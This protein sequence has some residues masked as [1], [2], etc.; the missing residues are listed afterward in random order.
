MSDQAQVLFMQRTDSLSASAKLFDVPEGYG[1]HQ[2][3]MYSAPTFWDDWQ[4]TPDRHPSPAGRWFQVPDL[5][6]PFEA[7]DTSGKPALEIVGIFSRNVDSASE[8]SGLG[9]RAHRETFAALL[10][11]WS[12]AAQ[13]ARSQDVEG[14]VAGYVVPSLVAERLYN[15][16]RLTEMDEYGYSCSQSA[17]DRL[18]ALAARATSEYLAGDHYSLILPIITVSEDGGIDLQWRASNR[19]VLISIPGERSEE[20]RY[21]AHDHLLPDR[22]IG[23]VLPDETSA[24]F[25]LVWLNA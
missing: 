7:L 9:S 12:Q 2:G 3:A 6:E 13:P 1:A 18:L 20:I 8:L 11:E 24:A 23:A 4:V 16:Q 22:D 15:A 25:L 17:Y 10:A 14:L 21:F 5:R 19:N